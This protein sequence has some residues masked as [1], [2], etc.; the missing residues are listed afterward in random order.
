VLA[1]GPG[2]AGD[3]GPASVEMDPELR[4]LLEAAETPEARR[5]AWRSFLQAE[6]A[7]L[8]GMEG[9]VSAIE[10]GASLKD[11][12]VD[13]RVGMELLERFDGKLDEGNRVS[14][15]VLF[16]YSSIDALAGYLDSHVT[17]AVQERAA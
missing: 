15:A 1:E 17:V 13:S 9:D 12:G 14:A 10:P 2:E 4:A 8:L 7:H 16:Q 6:V 11:L 5:E 3:D